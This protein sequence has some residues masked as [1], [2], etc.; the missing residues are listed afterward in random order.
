MLHDIPERSP[1]MSRAARALVWIRRLVAN[2]F[3]LFLASAVFVTWPLA[4]RLTDA[5][6]K[7]TEEVATV[8]LFNLW[9]VWWNAEWLTFDGRGYWDAP[10]F[11]PQK[12][13]FALSEPQPTAMAV[14]PI[15]WCGGSPILAYNVYLLASLWLNGFASAQLLRGVGLGR[16]SA[17]AGGL[18]VQWLPYVQWQLGVLQLVPLFGEAWTFLALKRLA[19]RPCL[20]RGA[21]V[22]AAFGLSYLTCHHNGL[23]FAVLLVVSAPWMVGRAFLTRGFWVGVLAAAI[24][25]GLMI[26]PSAVI[27][28]RLFRAQEFKRTRDLAV[29]LSLKPADY[30]V[31]YK[32]PVRLR[33]LST[34]DRRPW[35]PMSP[36]WIKVALAVIGA[37]VSLWR[38]EWRAWGLCMLW[39]IAAGFCLSLGPE[40]KW[41]WIAPYDA[42]HSVVPGFEHVRNVHRFALFAQLAT[43]WLAACGMDAIVSRRRPAA[44]VPEVSS[45]LRWRI[46]SWGGVVALAVLG[47]CESWPRPQRLV[48]LPAPKFKP[49]WLAYLRDETPPE[50]VVVCLPFPDA[51]DVGAYEIETRWMFGQMFHYRALVNGYSGY[52]PEAYL[53]AQDAGW[54]VPEEAGLKRLLELGVNFVVLDRTRIRDQGNVAGVKGGPYMTRVHRDQIELKDIYRLEAGRSSRD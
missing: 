17:A 7:G 50:S 16:G 51:A 29:S 45:G 19:D 13:A 26:A 53:D 11:A 41:K 48:E 38:R 2:Q 21:V 47:C 27:Q 52:F 31:T 37:V 44:A 32:S 36:G 24:V 20:W 12:Q 9:T 8:P 14:A 1:G 39:L 49:S 10:I 22:G 15:I 35:W 25:A 54:E 34:E 3:V 23:F 18:F 28:R 4:T 5:L 30:T 46:A 42:V 33:D 6:P 43:A 40:A